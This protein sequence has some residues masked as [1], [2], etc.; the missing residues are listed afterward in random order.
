MQL[1]EELFR[2]GSLPLSNTP[3][4]LLRNL[5]HYQAVRWFGFQ[6]IRLTS[7]FDAR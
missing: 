6:K 2:R 5:W 7:S 3:A 4:E 1:A